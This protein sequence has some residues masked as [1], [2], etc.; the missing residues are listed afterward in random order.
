MKNVTSQLMH[1]IKIIYGIL[2]EHYEPCFYFPWLLFRSIDRKDAQCK[3]VFLLVI[4]FV[5]LYKRLK[6]YLVLWGIQDCEMG[7]VKIFT[8]LLSIRRAMAVS[9]YAVHLPTH[10]LLK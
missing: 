8:S 5:Y 1:S 3:L 7:L 4:N 9:C 2:V 6:K 10:L